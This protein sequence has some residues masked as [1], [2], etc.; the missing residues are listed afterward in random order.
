MNQKDKKLELF[1][2][3]LD[4]ENNCVVQFDKHKKNVVYALADAALDGLGNG[5]S[6]IFDILANTIYYVLASNPN[7]ELKKAFLEN[8]EES[9]PKIREAVMNVGKLVVG[10]TDALAE[11][12]MNNIQEQ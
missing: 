12:L 9:V 6:D 11:M 5:N 3:V 1:S 8:L 7:G 4:E 10:N 2:V